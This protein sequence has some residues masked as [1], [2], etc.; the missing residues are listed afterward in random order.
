MKTTAS[1]M[2]IIQSE[3][4][5]NGLN[6]F[7][8]KVDGTPQIISNNDKFTYI[9]KVAQYDEDVQAVVDRTFFMNFKFKNET[10]D[11]FFKRSFITRF[12]DRQ[13]GN[14]TVDLFANHL[15][16]FSILNE[17][18]IDN[19][20]TNFEKYLNGDNTT[21]TKSTTNEKDGHNDANITLPQDNVSLDLTKNTADYADTN[22]I[23][24]AFADTVATGNNH[25][26]AY[27]ADVLDKMAE[28]WDNLMYRFDKKLFLQ[29]W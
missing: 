2:D 9:R 26:N 19:L 16:S 28:Q 29:I 18:Y 21:D 13:I 1:L 23:Y 15:V 10:T 4:I 20:V 12:L 8:N 24:R 17:A 6:E 3:L 14:Q 11:L 25:S 22:D 7:V 5:N 27:N